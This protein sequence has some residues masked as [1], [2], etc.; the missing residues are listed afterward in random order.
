MPAGDNVTPLL[1]TSTASSTTN[2]TNTTSTV[3]VVAST[4]VGVTFVGPPTGAVMYVAALILNGSAAAGNPAGGVFV[5]T[6]STLGSG[7]T[8]YDPSVEPAAKLSQNLTA[9]TVGGTVTDV[10]TGLTPGTTYNA[11]CVHWSS[12]GTV[13]FFNQKLTI[14]TL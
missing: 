8:V 7:T 14:L 1:V 5:R 6:G 2:T 10:I 12:S 4:V 9:G 11:V 13:A 3:P